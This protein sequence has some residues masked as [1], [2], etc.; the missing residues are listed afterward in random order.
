MKK[1]KLFSKL[2][3][4]VL[5]IAMA[6]G[7]IASTVMASDLP[8]PAQKG[9][10][11]VHKYSTMGESVKPGDGLEL[12]A[13]EKAQL[14]TPLA[15]AGFT[16]Y[17][18]DSA[19][20]IKSTTTPDE[21]IANAT[22]V[23]VELFTDANG[24]IVWSNLDLG[25]YVLKETTQPA[26]HNSVASSIIKVPTG[27]TASG[28]GWNYDI[29][30][31]PKNV[32]EEKISKEVK[33][34]DYAIGDTVEW[35]F[36]ASLIQPI[37]A[38]DPA[39][40]GTYVYGTAKVTDVLDTRLDYVDTTSVYLS[41][42]KN[43]QVALTKDVDYTATYNAATN[44]VVWELTEAGMDKASA[45]QASG[46]TIKFDTKINATAA[47]GTE[48]IEN[49]GTYDW[50][51]ADGSEAGKAEVGGT[52]GG[53]KPSIT[54]ATVKVLK[55]DSVDNTIL[56][57][58]AEFKIAASEADAQ[59][60]NYL[61]NPETGAAWV[62]TTNANG[63]ASFP[64]LELDGTNDTSYFLVETKA[65]TDYIKRDAI[66]EVVLNSTD[67]VGT[68]KV[69][70]QKVG[71][72]PIDETKPN[73]ELPKTGGMGTILFTVAGLVLILGAT[74]ILVKSRKKNA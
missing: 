1:N 33:E 26:G 64:G 73:F 25:Y 3:T 35:T 7:L 24:E 8:D 59:A 14:G 5:T 56:L 46:L 16:L 20:E 15:G 27:I 43:P 54:L 57:P 50:S 60:G 61:T 37:K 18:V 63:E 45:E 21:A 66:F 4:A 11:T 38:E 39:N 32:K 67:K 41:G 23:D 22:A 52:D 49:G 12:S 74:T 13:A 17:K 9:S 2:T 62:V 55:V 28:E 34:G 53:E 30:V 65:P 48:S 58:D 47:S 40:P 69:E 51:N 70:N 36:G 6:T 68:V 29:H 44:T 42:G 31:Y 19:F 72:P 10:I 71:N